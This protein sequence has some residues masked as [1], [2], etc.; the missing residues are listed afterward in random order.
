V[1]E[2]PSGMT[3]VLYDYVRQVQCNPSFTDEQLRIVD[4][5][6]T[7]SFGHGFSCGLGAAS[8][9][10]GESVFEKIPMSDKG[11]PIINSFLKMAIVDKD[12]I[13]EFYK[14]GLGL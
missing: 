12:E 2:F 1:K 7:A 9:I 5:L 8:A 6:I 13:V 10:T 4:D 14:E 3:R 11:D